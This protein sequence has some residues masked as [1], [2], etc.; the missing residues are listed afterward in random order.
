VTA[1]TDPWPTWAA[2]WPTWRAARLRE[3]AA[4]SSPRFAVGRT[5]ELVYDL[6]RLARDGS[7]PAVPIYIDSPLATNVTAVFAGHPEIFDDREDLIARVK[8][9]FRFDLV[10]YT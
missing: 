8:D 2:G 6:H 5:Q 1:T 7:I 4:S 3:A 9:L 10:H